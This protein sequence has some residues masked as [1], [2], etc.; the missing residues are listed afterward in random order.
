[1]FLIQSKHILIFTSLGLMNVLIIKN[2]DS[3]KNKDG[4]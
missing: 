3:F 2:E 4:L 1:M